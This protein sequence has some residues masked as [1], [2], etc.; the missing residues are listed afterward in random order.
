M[1]ASCIGLTLSRIDREPRSTWAY[2]R[3]E[4]WFNCMLKEN[5]DEQ[6]KNDFRMA[7]NYFL[8]IVRIIQPVREKRDKQIRR[9]I[10]I[11]KCVAIVLWR[12]STGNQ[13]RTTAKASD[14]GKSTAVQIAVSTAVQ[15]TR[16]FCSEVQRLASRFIRFPNNKR[17]PPNQ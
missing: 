12:L 11:E 1:F 8:E 6:R 9:A 17:K 10:P 4:L 14:V 16:D 5:F 2:E 7:R 3:E 15:I 13:F